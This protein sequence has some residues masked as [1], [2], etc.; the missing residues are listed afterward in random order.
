MDS[1]DSARRPPIRRGGILLMWRVGDAVG[2][3]GDDV[4]ERYGAFCTVFRIRMDG[5][6]PRTD[7]ELA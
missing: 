2:F 6:L 7:I 1:V 5:F 3:G 4:V